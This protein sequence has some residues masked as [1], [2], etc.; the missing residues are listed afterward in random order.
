GLLGAVETAVVKQAAGRM[1]A[2]CLPTEAAQQKIY[3]AAQQAVKR[4]KVGQAAKPLRLSPPITLAVEL[5]SSDMA[6]QAML[7][8]GSRRE[9]RR[10]EYTADDML[11][12]YRAIRAIISLA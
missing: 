1:T 2:E 5:S 4:F 10:V 7:L 3:E 8:P 11:T 12:A 6:D 9:G